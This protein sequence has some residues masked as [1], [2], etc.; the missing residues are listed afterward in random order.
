[1]FGSWQV[2]QEWARRMPHL[3]E[4]LLE[5]LGP[6]PLRPVPQ[7]PRPREPEGAKRAVISGFLT[8]SSPWE[9]V[10]LGKL[11]E[12]VELVVVT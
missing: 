9:A 1:M 10:R 8:Q 3:V 4:S 7:S 5:L 11:L 12:K 2:R 6:R